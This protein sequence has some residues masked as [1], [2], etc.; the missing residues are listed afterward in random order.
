M[1]IV[2][3]TWQRAGIDVQPYVMP[4]ALDRDQKPAQNLRPSWSMASRPGQS[5]SA[6]SGVI[7]QI[8]T[9]AN[10]WSG[11]NRAGWSHP[12]CERLWAGFNSTLDR[13]EQ[14]GYYVQMMRLRSEEATN[15]PLHYSLNVISHL[16]AL[17]EPEFG[18]PGTGLFG[19]RR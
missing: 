4:N 16:S 2:A 13:S 15:I 14:R 8:G 6:E 5:T 3:S 9:L 12:E 11:N 7:E 1:A 19:T 10:R 17:R 18:T